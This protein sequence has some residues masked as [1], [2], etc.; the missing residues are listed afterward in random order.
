M[1]RESEPEGAFDGLS[2]A[3]AMVCWDTEAEVPD[4]YFSHFAAQCSQNF[5]EGS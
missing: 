3:E 2:C 5:L 4:I 1:T